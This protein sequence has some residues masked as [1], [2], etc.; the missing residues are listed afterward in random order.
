VYLQLISSVCLT[1][2]KLINRYKFLFFIAVCKRIGGTA[3]DKILHIEYNTGKLR[4]HVVG[5]GQV[6]LIGDNPE[7][8]HDSTA[9]GDVPLGLLRGTVIYKMSLIPPSICA[10]RNIRH[11]PEDGVLSRKALEAQSYNLSRTNIVP[12][13]PQGWRF[14][15]EILQSDERCK[16]ITLEERK[17]LRERVQKEVEKAEKSRRQ[18]QKVDSSCADQPNARK[19]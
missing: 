13:T 17:S 7:N 18:G 10:I 16:E 14:L 6:W 9:Y 11:T 8:S 4:N 19:S 3:G 12:T 2:P 1:P 5:D 15:L